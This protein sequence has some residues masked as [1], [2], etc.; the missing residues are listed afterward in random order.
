[1]SSFV[2]RDIEQGLQEQIEGIGESN[3]VILIEG[4]R[5]VGKTTVV[6]ETLKYLK[7][8]F[9][10]FNLEANPEVTHK[11]DACANFENFTELIET[12]FQF[13]IGK[14]K[15]LFIDEAQESAK[16]GQF[17][18]F[19]KEEWRNTLVILSGSSMSRIFR[20]AHYPVGRVTTIHVQPFSF[21]EFLRASDHAA[22]IKKLNECKNI[23]SLPSWGPEIHPLVLSLLEQFLEVGGLPEVVTTY[24]SKGPWKTKRENLL[25]GYYQDFR[26]V[27][28]EREQIYLTA[29]LKTTAHL[30]GMPFKNSHAAT[31]LEGGKNQ[32]IIEAISQLEAWRMILTVEQRG[33]EVEKHFHPKRYLFD[34]GIARQLRESALPPL[35]LVNP[36]DPSQRQSIG[37]VV[38]NVVANF[39]S[40]KNRELSGWKKS[41][42]GSEIDFVLKTDRGI[43]PL[44]CKAALKIIDTHLHGVLD[45]LKIHKGKMAVIIGLAPFEVQPFPGG[46][47]VVIIPLY[48]LDYLDDILHQIS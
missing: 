34:T 32:K 13:P 6:R 40:G 2:L 36:T 33:T 7:Q 42:S 3:N 43:V 28:G 19:I 46:R 14:G 25:Y 15:I 27:H 26:R 38:K 30:L 41:S 20:Q 11:I 39:L 16:L 37:G 21:R 5:Q 22:L 48:L 18:R 35:S 29:V 24:F 23:Q 8:P 17:V 9:T 12:V 4:P 44:E 31:L 47:Q 1:M 10:E 45:F